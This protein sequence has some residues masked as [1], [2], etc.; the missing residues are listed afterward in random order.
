VPGEEL[1]LSVPGWL[2]TSNGGCT[3]FPNNSLLE[4][5]LDILAT[6]LLDSD[7]GKVLDVTGTIVVPDLLDRWAVEVAVLHSWC[8]LWLSELLHS[9]AASQARACHHGMIELSWH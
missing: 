3:A 4:D 2:N 9:A 7:V 5:C 6:A 1:D 8:W